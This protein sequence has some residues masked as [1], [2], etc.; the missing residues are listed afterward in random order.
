MLLYRQSVKVQRINSEATE[1]A[2]EQTA[3]LERTKV[4][5][6]AYERAKSVY[7]SALGQLEKQLERLQEQ[8]DRL[9][10]QLAREQDTSNTLRNQIHE[11]RRQVSELERT[12]GELRRQLVLAGVDPALMGRRNTDDLEEQ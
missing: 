10:E 11:L 8:L 2:A 3:E 4:D 6:A 12:V 7:E 1:R 5:A 9:N